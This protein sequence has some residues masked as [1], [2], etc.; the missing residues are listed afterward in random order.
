MMDTLPI[1]LDDLAIDA[2]R[3]SEANLHSILNHADSG[4]ALYDAS[5]R[6]IA[7][8]SLAQELSFALYGKRL[9]KGRHL[10]NYFPQDRHEI[11]K[12]ITARVLKG[13]KIS[14]ELSFTV[15][16]A[17]TWIEVTWIN[18]RNPQRKNWGFILASKDITLRKRAAMELADRNKALEQFANII[19]HNLRAP[20]A[21]IINL[22]DVLAM[23]DTPEEQESMLQLVYESARTLDQVIRDIHYILKAKQHISDLKENINIPALIGDIRLSIQHIITKEQAI[24]DC[25]LEENIYSIRSFIYNILYNLIYNS[26]KY[27][28]AERAPLIRVSA[29]RSIN[30]FCITVADNGKGIDLAKHG[31]QLFG[32]YKRFDS[33]VEGS[34]LGLFMV[35]SQIEEL[36]GRILVES[37]LGVG[38]SFVVELPVLPA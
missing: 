4:Y 12:N 28:H 33:S 9:V 5:L 32:L 11:L 13:E 18:V 10:L 27:R 15:D 25:D 16:G 17:E 7:F 6:L 21:N 23:V 37:T 19:S 24:I 36:G 3:K 14:Y 38:T 20:V 26:L 31:A 35:K 2:L 8:N 22:I 34:G 1:G 30:L 29:K